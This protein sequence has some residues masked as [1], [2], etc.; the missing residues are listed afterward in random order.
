LFNKTS[1]FTI[2]GL[3]L[4]IQIVKTDQGIEVFAELIILSFKSYTGFNPKRVISKIPTSS[5]GQNLFFLALKNLYCQNLSHSRYKTTST[6]CSK[7][8]GQA[9]SPHLVICQIIKEDILYFLENSEIFSET[10]FT[11]DTLQATLSKEVE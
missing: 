9:I 4:S 2:T 5:A 10:Y 8:L 6:I 3:Q 1:K 11:C 7:Y